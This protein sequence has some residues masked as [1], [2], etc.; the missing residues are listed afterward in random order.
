VVLTDHNTLAPKPIEG[1]RDG[2]LVM[3]GTE[4]ST[5]DGHVLG[6]GLGDPGFRFSGGAEDALQDI[7]DLEGAAFVSH[8]TSTRP[9]FRWTGWSRPG[10]WGLEVMNGDS[11]WRAA[12]PLGLARAVA[13]YPLNR[14]YALLSPFGMPKEALERWDALLARRDVPAVIGADAHQR[15]ELRRGLVL[16]APSYESVFASLRQ[17]VLLDGA[18]AGDAARDSRAVVEALARGRSYAAL[19]GLAP[20]DGFSFVAVRA[21]TQATMGDTVAPAPDLLLRAAGRV[22]REARL[23]LLRDGRVVQEGP[24]PLEVRAE[25]EGVYRV[26]AFLPRWEAPWVMTNPIY[27]FGPQ[28]AAERRAAAAWPTPPPPPAPA[29]LLD[30]FEGETWFAGVAD[31]RSTVERA[32]QAAGEGEGGSV[33]A[34]FRFRLGEPTADHPDVFAALINERPPGTLAGRQGIVLSL[35]GD[36]VY[37]VWFQVRDANP[38]SRDGGTEWWF[39][40][41]KTAPEWRR[42]AI[43]FESLRSINPATDGRLDLDKVRALVF[44]VDKGTLAPGTAGTIWVDDIGVY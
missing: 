4:V 38:A 28:R 6:I 35:R 8:P 39:T 40:S 24:A 10:P 42:V 3:V 33:A 1:V 2:L 43:P 30:D 41:L 34:R 17:Y 11:A 25:V 37:R 5:T 22:P 12:G 13:A 36:G 29:A 14:R 18:P 44:V 26:E 23:R 32:V 19:E 7:R 16:R 20:A 9:D 15:I 31:A 27:V 21:G